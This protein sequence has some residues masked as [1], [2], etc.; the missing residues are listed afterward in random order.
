[1]LANPWNQDTSIKWTP[2]M[3]P[4]VS[5]LERFHCR[6]YSCTIMLLVAYHVYRIHSTHSW[7]R[8]II[9]TGTRVMLRLPR[10]SLKSE[11]HMRYCWVLQQIA[12]LTFS[13][14][15]FHVRVCCVHVCL[16]EEYWSI[17]SHSV[18]RV[19]HLALYS[20]Y[21]DSSS[22]MWSNCTCSLLETCDHN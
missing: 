7:P 13:T 18:G 20:V 17:C 9:L 22:I 11:R 19:K 12:Y 1:M 21:W 6:Y 4:S 8:S 5:R 16:P 2:E 14:H 3:D 10:S 15:M